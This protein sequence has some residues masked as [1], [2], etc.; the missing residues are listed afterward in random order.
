MYFLKN[1]YK[2]DDDDQETKID[3]K[4][5]DDDFD[6]NSIYLNGE[7]GEVNVDNNNQWYVKYTHNDKNQLIPLDTETLDIS[8]SYA[9]NVWKLQGSQFDNIVII[10]N[11]SK[12]TDRSALYTSITRASKFCII[13]TTKESLQNTLQ[14]NP[15]RK[16]KLKEFLQ[17]KNV[18]VN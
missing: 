12:F 1:K 11:G 7:R 6:D 14:N 10:L 16:T 17:L 13:F 18:K 4:D 8:P 5:K 3:E 9:S 2:K 15:I